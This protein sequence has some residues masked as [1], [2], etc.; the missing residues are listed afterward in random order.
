MVKDAEEFADEDKMA[1]EK[2]DARNQLDNFVYSVK[3]SVND[4]EKLADKL[5]DEDKETVKKALE[6]VEEWLKTNSDSTKEEFEEKQKEL[7]ETVN[8]ILQE[9]GKNAGGAGQ[10]APEEEDYDATTEL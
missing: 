5:A 6:E 3:N 4:P 1:K 9:A 8:P 10:E 7:E 2:I